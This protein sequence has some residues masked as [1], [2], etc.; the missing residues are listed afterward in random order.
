M[1]NINTFLAKIQTLNKA[2]II[3]V[4][5]PSLSAVE[6]LPL[7]VKQQKDLIK[8]SLDGSLAGILINNT[9]NDIVDAQKA[10]TAFAVNGN[11]SNDAVIVKRYHLWGQENNIPTYVFERP[12]DDFEKSRNHSMQKL[13]D[14]VT[15]IGWNPNDVHGYWCDCDETIIIDPK[16]NKNQF[17]ND[18]YMTVRLAQYVKE[19]VDPSLKL[20]TLS[21]WIGSLHCWNVEKEVYT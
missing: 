17:K 18:I 6:F 4:N 19:Q 8:S 14:V 9:I 16:F 20:G 3:T 11:H 15:E 7:S 13:R 10:R 2:N 12:F 1:S 5:L 21:M